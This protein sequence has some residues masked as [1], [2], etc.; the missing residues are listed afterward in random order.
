MSNDVSKRYIGLQ[1]TA[2]CI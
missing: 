2:V 1:A